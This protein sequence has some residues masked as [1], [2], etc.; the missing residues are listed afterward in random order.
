[1]VIFSTKRH[2]KKL[3]EH[4][5]YKEA[6]EYGHKLEKKH[7]KDANFFFIMGGIYYILEDAKNAIQ[8]FDKVLELKENDI[9]AL[10]LKAN[11]HLFLKEHQAVRECCN[12]ILDLEPDNKDAQEMLLS[13]DEN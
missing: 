9:E 11:V 2:L 5:D 13:L 4:G 3:A 6:L 1:M 7:S 8:Y 10:N 12:K